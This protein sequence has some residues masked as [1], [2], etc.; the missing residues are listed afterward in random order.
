MSF[1][2]TRLWYAPTDKPVHLY[3]DASGAPARL[4]AVLLIDGRSYY[5]DMDVPIE[6][7]AIFTRR[8][9]R[10]IMSLELL[11]IALGLSTFAKQCADRR[12]CIFSDNVGAEGSSRKGTARSWDHARI[13]HCIWKKAVTLGAHI[14]VQRVPTDDNIADLPSREKYG[15]LE[16]I[17]AVH[18]EPFLG[19]EFWH[20]E[21]WEAL[22]VRQAFS[23]N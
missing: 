5:T 10:Q 7:L 19:P 9:D 23:G 15:L 17:G 13:V 8:G 22:S 6:L 12:V 21:A 20:P 11:A 4:A 3:A 18:T 16:R 2:E 1:A 14:W